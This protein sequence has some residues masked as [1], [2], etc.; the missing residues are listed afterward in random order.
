M[1]DG[2]GGVTIGSEISGDVRWVFAEKFTM[3][4][5]NLDRALRLKTNAMRGGTLE[6]IFM[7]DVTIGQVASAVVHVDFIYKEGANGSF[8][9]VVRD[10]NVERVSSPKSK[11]AL[12]LRA[13]PDAPITDVRIVNCQFNDV[14]SPSVIEN[15]RGLTYDRVTINGKPV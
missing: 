14:A 6:H 12:F 7:R 10:I 5:P 11:H 3:D 2:Q 4:S 15:V 9:P 13:F 1:K 8:P